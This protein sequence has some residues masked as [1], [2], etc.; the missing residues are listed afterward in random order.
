MSERSGYYNLFFS[1]YYNIILSMTSVFSKDVNQTK[2]FI[3]EKTQTKESVEYLSTGNFIKWNSEMSSIINKSKSGNSKVTKYMKNYV[4]AGHYTTSTT[5]LRQ[6]TDTESAKTINSESCNYEDPIP[7]EIKIPKKLLIVDDSRSFRKFL[8]QLL[9]LEGHY[10]EVASNGLLALNMVKATLST[11]TSDLYLRNY[12]A[13]IINLMMP[14]MNGF[15][16]IIAIRE[17]GYTGAILGM[18]ACAPDDQDVA[19]ALLYAGATKVLFKPI[20]MDVL[21]EIIKSV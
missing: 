5:S 20:K 18:T 19:D 12:D 16:A 21:Y 8:Y 6:S 10:C 11:N 3:D 17:L 13:I 2:E 14:V 15:D 7:M 4:R 1:L 9:E